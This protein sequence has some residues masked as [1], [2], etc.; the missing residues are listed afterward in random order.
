M[1]LLFLII[2]STIQKNVE[3]AM[4]GTWKNQLG[5]T[6]EIKNFE[7]GTF[8]GDYHTKVGN[9]KVVTPYIGNYQIT[10]F[11]PEGSTTETTAFLMSWIVQWNKRIKDS[12][13]PSTTAWTGQV[14]HDSITKIDSLWTLR[15]YTDELGLWNAV[16][17]NKDLFTKDKK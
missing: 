15:R 9:V 10:K 1:I 13:S 5:S 14:T 3:D 7:N 2:M 8:T 11:T 12:D 6:M 4:I 17:T 16:M